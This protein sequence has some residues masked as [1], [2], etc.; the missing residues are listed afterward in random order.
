MSYCVNC[1]VE[2]ADSEKKCPLCLTEVYNPK[3]PV[4]DN[5]KTPYPPLRPQ[6]AQKVSKNSI[7]SILTILFLLPIALCVVCDISINHTMLWSGYV[8]GSFLLLYIIV[9][10]PIAVKKPNPVIALCIDGVSILGFLFF[11]ERVTQGGWFIPFALPVTL[12]LTAAVVL[13]TF[14][15]LYTNIP[16]LIITAFTFVLIGVFC[17]FVEVQIN[18]AFSVRDYLQWSLYPL[19]TFCILGGAMVYINFNKPLQER[20]K[21]KFFI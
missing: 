3:A 1:G 2:L 8:I 5:V 10:F 6:T 17:I 19:V 13:I 4:K 12:C 18:A 21:R 16:G 20:L 15:T 9:V 14:F 7:I 11:I